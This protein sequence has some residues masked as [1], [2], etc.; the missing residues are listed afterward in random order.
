MQGSLDWIFGLVGDTRETVALKQLTS[1]T[2]T[3]SPETQNLPLHRSPQNHV[4]KVKL[5]STHMH[6]YIYTHTCIYRFMHN[7][8]TY[9]Q[10]HIHAYL[11]TSANMV[12]RNPFNN[13][14]LKS[15]FLQKT[16]TIYQYLA[17]APCNPTVRGRDQGTSWCRSSCL[18]GACVVWVILG[19][20]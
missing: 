6:T 11:Q 13:L 19:S 15:H 20:V 17:R 8:P 9:L 1:P 7:M 12:W 16:P 5:T 14:S 3:K 4:C 10:A 2:M 18:S